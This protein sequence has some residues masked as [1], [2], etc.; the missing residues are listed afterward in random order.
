MCPSEPCVAFS[1]RCVENLREGLVELREDV[2]VGLGKAVTIRLPR[3]Q[4]R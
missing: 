4:L 2:K 3:S 1:T